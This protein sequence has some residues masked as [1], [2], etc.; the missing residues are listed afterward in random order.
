MPFS[1]AQYINLATFR[2]TGVAVETPVWFAE[3]GGY[4][5]AFSN[6]QAGK[7]KR[8]K[9][10]SQCR[11][12]TCTVTGRLTGSW[13]DSVATLLN[14]AA[15]IKLAHKALLKKYGIQMRLLDYAAWM[16]GK[17]KQR[18]FIRIEKP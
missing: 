14:N 11:I 12:A 15:E 6:N 9:N 7:V 8:L 10:N 16:G 1:K 4:F 13:K 17:I 2:K 18:S 5:Y 3:Y